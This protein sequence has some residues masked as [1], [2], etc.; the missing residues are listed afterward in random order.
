MAI[1][2]K[3]QKKTQQALNLVWLTTMAIDSL[4]LV[5]T[6]F[7]CPSDLTKIFNDFV[8]FGGDVGIIF[9]V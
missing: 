8:S 2:L 5:L 4:T 7:S 9:G 3:K 1:K 6:T